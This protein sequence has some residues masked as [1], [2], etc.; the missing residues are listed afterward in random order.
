MANADTAEAVRFTELPATVP[1]PAVPL[2]P[3]L[4]APGLAVTVAQLAAVFAAH[5]PTNGT[6]PRAGV[7]GV[8]WI[9]C[10]GCGHVYS[11]AAPLCPTLAVVWSLLNRR[12]H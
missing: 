9:R 8:N 10:P 12:R 2:D 3:R 6:P 5:W 4:T 7:A 11:E 1:G